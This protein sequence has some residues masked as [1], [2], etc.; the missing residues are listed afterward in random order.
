MSTAEKVLKMQVSVANISYRARD[1]SRLTCPAQN[2]ATK[3]ALIALRVC[4]MNHAMESRLR[5]PR[6]HRK[7][8]V[9]EYIGTSMILPP[10]EEDKSRLWRDQELL[11]QMQNNAIPKIRALF[12]RQVLGQSDCTPI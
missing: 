2:A 12:T 5:M 8:E 4:I 9:I 6:S 11:D 1:T 3:T 7:F 10:P